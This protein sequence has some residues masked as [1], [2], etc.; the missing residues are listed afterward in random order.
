M[1]VVN[2]TSTTDP[3]NMYNYLNSYILNPMVF[4]IILIIILAY[5][6][7]SSNAVSG[8]GNTQGTSSDGSNLMGIVI[9]VILVC[10]LIVNALQ[11]FF[12]INVTAYISDIFAPVKKVDIVVDQ[13]LYQPAPVPEIRFKKQVFNIPGN[14]YNYENAK[15]LCK[16]YGADLASYDQIE[17]AYNNG[18]EWCNYGWSANQQAL[19]PTQKKTYDYLQTVPGHENDCGR[20]GING[21]YMANPKLRFGVNCYGNKPKITPEEEELMKTTPAYPQTA[22]DIAFQKRVDF[23]KTKVTDILVSPF[24][25]NSWGSL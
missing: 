23:W 25:K 5:Y 17:K 2:T 18:A 16:A 12:S 8:L 9:V 13:S 11:Y 4:I 14:Y 22:Q 24:N 10:L 15:A 1:E 19:F 7:F 3:V 20:T 6:L 21:G